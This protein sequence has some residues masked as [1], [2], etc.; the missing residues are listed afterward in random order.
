MKNKKATAVASTAALAMAAAVQAA[1]AVPTSS[2][3]QNGD[4]ASVISSLIAEAKPLPI[5]PPLPPNH[6]HAPLVVPLGV[7]AAIPTMLG[8]EEEV[9]HLALPAHHRE[10]GPLHSH[11]HGETILVPLNGLPGVEM[12]EAL[13]GVPI[14]K[15]G[16]RSRVHYR[17]GSPTSRSPDSKWIVWRKT[18]GSFGTTSKGHLA[19][20]GQAGGSPPSS[21]PRLQPQTST[22]STV[23]AVVMP[24]HQT[25]EAEDDCENDEIELT[26]RAHLTGLEPEPEPHDKKALHYFGQPQSKGEHEHV[27]GD[28]GPNDNDM[29]G[30]LFRRRASAPASPVAA[31]AASLARRSLVADKADEDLAV[32]RR[33]LYRLSLGQE[34]PR[35]Y[36]FVAVGKDHDNDNDDYDYEDAFFDEDDFDDDAV[37]IRSPL[38]AHGVIFDVPTEVHHQHQ[39]QHRQPRQH[40]HHHQ[41]ARDLFETHVRPFLG[42]RGLTDEVQAPPAK[43]DYHSHGPHYHNSGSYSPNSIDSHG[44]MGRSRGMYKRGLDPHEPREHDAFAEDEGEDELERRSHKSGSEAGRRWGRPRHHGKRSIEPRAVGEYGPAEW[45][46]PGPMP[47]EKRSVGLDMGKRRN[48]DRITDMNSVREMQLRDVAGVAPLT[49]ANLD[50]LRRTAESESEPAQQLEKRWRFGSRH[51][52]G[53]STHDR[54]CHKKAESDYYSRRDESDP[55]N[56]DGPLKR[57]NVEPEVYPGRGKSKAHHAPNEEAATKPEG[58]EEEEEGERVEKRSVT[59]NAQGGGRCFA[60]DGASQTNGKREAAEASG[61]QMEKRAM[62]APDYLVTKRPLGGAR[63]QKRMVAGTPPF[64]SGKCGLG[65]SRRQRSQFEVNAM[66]MVHKRG[67]QGELPLQKRFK[68]KKLG[69]EKQAGGSNLA[70]MSMTKKGGFK[71]E[72][73]K[74]NPKRKPKRKPKVEAEAKPV[75]KPTTKPEGKPEGLPKGN[76][77]ETGME[78]AL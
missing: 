26:K 1:P 64:S 3:G 27:D 62:A 56:L 40:H 4:A 60:S 36:D 19:N 38:T 25:T 17:S 32:A 78:T 34:S 43:R 44:G 54:N 31:A 47:V 75:T 74:P 21:P 51:S 37:S 41:Q 76:P 70:T 2:S 48:M 30:D 57:R 53:C 14:R 65:C 63:L 73:T 10:Q 15:I 69:A 35:R 5:P 49:E 77:A 72:T 68:A 12:N 9:I 24:E 6:P 52:D 16:H 29:R 23:V 11:A 20:F 33:S 50:L 28:E 61:I 8:G 45:G 46:G 39:H 18:D 22:S 58:E 7:G 71:T 42:R 59:C 13:V 66:P 55:D 67:L